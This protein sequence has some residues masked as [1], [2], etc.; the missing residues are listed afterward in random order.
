MQ[1]GDTSDRILIVDDNASNIKILQE[2]LEDYDLQIATSGEDAL[3]LAPEFKPDLVMLDIMMPGIDGYEV[4]RRLRSNPDLAATKIIMVTAKALREERL[5]GYAAGADDY[6]VKPFDGQE[7]LAKVR[8]YLRLKSAEEFSNE[9]ATEVEAKTRAYRVAKE[10]AEDANT[11]K[12][13]FISVMTHEL[14]NPITAILGY[15][16]LLLASSGKNLDEEGVHFLETIID[17]SKHLAGLVSDI[18]DV[19]KIDRDVVDLNIV[20]FSATEFVH[21]TVDMVCPQLRDAGVEVV[22]TID[23]RATMITGDR[24]R[25]TQILINLLSNA[26]KYT[27]RGGEV[28]VRVAMEDPYAV[29]VSVSDTGVGIAPEHQEKLFAEFYQVDRKRDATL[30][31]TGIGLALTRRLVK[32]HG[33]EIGVKSALGEGSTFWF[34]VPVVADAVPETKGAET[35]FAALP[36]TVAGRRVLVAED[37]TANQAVLIDLLDRHD[38][39]TMI[40]ADGQEAIEMARYHHPDLILMDLR[41]PV[42]DGFTAAEKLRAMP[43]FADTPIVAV[44]ASRDKESIDRCLAAGC[45]EHL[46]KPIQPSELRRILERYLVAD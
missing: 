28:R 13:Q 32:L 17:S 25:C 4:C 40:A 7:L 29:R 41:M 8:V 3:M 2:R 16:D 10:A 31:G 33:G 36:R 23:E 20:S 26:L 27:E 11:A 37:D 43:Q 12:N 38:I 24:K 42:M 14:R 9:L 34:T 46:P 39:E 44:S 30:G 19:V 1:N 45:N 6:M 18:F 5:E 22:V 21:A 15:A 35:G